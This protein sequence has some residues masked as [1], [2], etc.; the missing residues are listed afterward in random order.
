MT[1]KYGTSAALAYKDKLK[2][3]A[4]GGVWKVCFFCCPTDCQKE[5]TDDELQRK[6]KAV[7][8]F[9]F[10]GFSTTS[11]GNFFETEDKSL[12]QVHSDAYF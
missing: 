5:L 7:S 1:Q 8:S 9:G 11:P 6:Y 12:L 4:T 3:V 10:G 2:T